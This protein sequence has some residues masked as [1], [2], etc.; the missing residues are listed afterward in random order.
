MPYQFYRLTKVELHKSNY[1]SGFT[2]TYRRPDDAYFAGWPEELTHTFGSADAT[3]KSASLDFTEDLDSMTLCVDSNARAEVHRDFE[4]FLFLPLGQTRS[5]PLARSCPTAGRTS[6]DLVRKRLIGF[7]VVE[8]GY[9]AGRRRIS[10]IC[11]IIDEI[12]CA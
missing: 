9:T 11:P 2:V 5:V 12:D 3:E 10:A 7:R 4:G 8:S 1:V 6:F